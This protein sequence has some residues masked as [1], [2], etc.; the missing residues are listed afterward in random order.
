[1]N[2][3]NTLNESYLVIFKKTNLNII[4]PINIEE[5]NRRGL[6]ES[7][8]DIIGKIRQSVKVTDPISKED[9]I[10][11]LRVTKRSIKIDTFREK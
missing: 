2:N 3:K 6:E 11:T 1:M 7:N 5:V 9:T 10:K 4:N 8:D